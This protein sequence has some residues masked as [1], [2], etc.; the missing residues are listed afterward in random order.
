MSGSI[1]VNLPHYGATKPFKRYFVVKCWK[2]FY[3]QQIFHSIS[4][5][6]I[7]LDLCREAPARVICLSWC[8]ESGVS[9]DLCQVGFNQSEACID[10]L[11]QYQLFIVI[12]RNA[13]D[14]RGQ[15]EDPGNHQGSLCSSVTLHVLRPSLS[16]CWIHRGQRWL[17]RDCPPLLHRLHHPGVNSFQVRIDQT[18]H[19]RE[20]IKSTRTML[21]VH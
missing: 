5:N 21:S 6:T 12:V 11:I 2:I 9:S 10:R 4:D 7:L 3:S 20:L 1:A 15:L 14:G 18:K 8:M 13:R 19:S 16:S 17:P